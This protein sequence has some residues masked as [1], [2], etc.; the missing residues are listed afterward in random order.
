MGRKKQEF[1]CQN[2]CKMNVFA[3]EAISLDNQVFISQNP[4]NCF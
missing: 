2:L 3:D 4:K 1:A